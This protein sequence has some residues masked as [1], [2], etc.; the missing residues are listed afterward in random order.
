MTT[1]D[2]V[3]DSNGDPVYMTL[4]GTTYYYQKNLQG[5]IIGIV[6][7][8]NVQ[9]V[10]YSYD[11]WGKLLGIGGPLA[12]TV[13]EANHLR[14]RGYYYDTETGLFY[15][16]ARYYDPEIGRFISPDLPEM[17]L[18]SD[19]I[20]GTN[21]YAYCYNNPIM[22]TDPSGLLPVWAKI[23]IGIVGIT[24]AVVATAA[25][26]GA[27]LPALIAALKFVAGSMA[28]NMAVSGL[29]GWIT[30]GASGL[31][32]GLID[33][34]INGFMWG[35]I[36]AAVSAAVNIV[37]T[38]RAAKAGKILRY[39]KHGLDQA[40]GR[41]GGKGVA[42]AAIR[43]TIKNPTKVKPQSGGRI[44]LESSQ[45]VVVLNKFGQIITTWAK[46][47]KFWR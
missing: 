43:H 11:A 47:R 10:T 19:N 40:L 45:A 2:Y 29:I 13:G 28:I 7:S 9:V 5:D 24:A 35:G 44:R 1:V 31:R 17:M 15:V 14:Y 37:N 25:T 12:S 33:G 38:I 27:A 6:D 30:G 21:L 20:I 22:Y 34:A 42:D 36:G 46:S 23:T 32:K 18:L 3:Y 4:N 39:T 8:D 26:G 41:D 16:G